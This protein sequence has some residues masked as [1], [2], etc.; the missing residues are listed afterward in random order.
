MVAFPGP[1][2]QGIGSWSWEKEET[3]RQEAGRT[4][5]GFNDGS[6][7]GS[8]GWRCS[9]AVLYRRRCWGRTGCSR[10]LSR[11]Q[12]AVRR[13]AGANR[14]AGSCSAMGL[15]CYTVLSN[16]VFNPIALIIFSFWLM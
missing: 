15:V 4:K 8:Q 9:G 1:S 3:K 13:S 2:V 5:V 11:V 16:S 7:A 12:R 14:A 10:S 6:L